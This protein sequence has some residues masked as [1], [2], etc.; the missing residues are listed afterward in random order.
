MGRKNPKSYW[1]VSVDIHWIVHHKHMNIQQKAARISK[2]LKGLRVFKRHSEYRSVLTDLV[3]AANVGLAE[4]EEALDSLYN[5]AD[6]FGIW[7][8]S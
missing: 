6:Y 2:A 1:R 5:F 4:Y 7:L 8:A 3:T